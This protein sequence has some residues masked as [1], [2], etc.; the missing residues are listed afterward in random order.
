MTPGA[1]Q[2]SAGAP[3]QAKQRS[4]PAL[5]RP[6]LVIAD[7]DPVVQCILRASLDL[8]FEVVG[9][10]GDGEEAIELVKSN[11]PDAALVDLVMPRGGGLRAVRGIL[12]VSPLTAV[13][14]ISGQRLRGTARQ[15]MNLGTIAYCRKGI[16]PRRLASSLRESIELHTAARRESAWTMLAWHCVAIDHRSRGEVVKHNPQ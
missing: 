9:L 16:D 7:D 3:D 15:L 11:Q 10:A 6:R 4:A 14:V 13:V 1:S 12:E 2:L 8:D 5:R